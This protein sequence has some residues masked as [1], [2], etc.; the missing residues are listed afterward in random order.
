MGRTIP[1]FRIALAIEKER[2]GSPSVMLWIRKIE[3]NL[4]KCGRNMEVIGTYRLTDL[5]CIKITFFIIMASSSSSSRNSNPII[6]TT[7]NLT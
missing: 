7:I 1:S 4:M 3:R 2:I 6:M 5:I